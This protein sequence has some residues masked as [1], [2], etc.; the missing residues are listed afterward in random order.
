MFLLTAL[1]KLCFTPDM[2]SENGFLADKRF[3]MFFIYMTNYH[4]HTIYTMDGTEAIIMNV[5]KM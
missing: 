5:R 2:P 4:T 1:E 3:N